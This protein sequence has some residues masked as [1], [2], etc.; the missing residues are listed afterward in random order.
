MQANISNCRYDNH[1]IQTTL[2][3]EIEILISSLPEGPTSGLA[4][5]GQTVV[6]QA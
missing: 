4:S 6:L 2:Q 1:K 5:Q 3:A